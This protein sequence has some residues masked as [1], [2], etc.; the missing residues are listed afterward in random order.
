[1]MKRF[2]KNIYTPIFIGPAVLV[3]FVFSVIPILIALG[4]SFTD[5]DLIGLADWSSIQFSGIDNYI[6]LFTDSRFISSIFNT[7]FYA[8]IG[9]PLVVVCS[10]SIALLLNYGTSKL[11]SFFRMV[12]FMPTITNIVAIA[13]IW[14]YLYNTDYGLFN[15]L[16]SLINVDE[17]PW[18]DDALMA[19]IS[20]IILAAWKGIGI[21]MIIYLAALQ[22]I[23]R[24]Y[25][26]AADMDGATR[27]QQL[28]H[29]TIPMLSYATFFVSVTTIIA[30]LQ[31]FEEPFVMTNGGPSDGTMSM[32]LFIYQKGFQSNEFGY[33][34]AASVVLFIIIIVVTLMQF[35]FRKTED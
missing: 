13:V 19:K 32:A 29:I 34:A 26:E 21:N 18:L 28:F 6:D 20:L 10:L 15:Y 1:M 22:A 12:Y 4:I 17:V 25:Y 16:L 35:K 31:F 23:P 3:L 27:W 14:G 24:M 5:M 30:W 8:L 7:L 11:F 9:V 2:S 33:A